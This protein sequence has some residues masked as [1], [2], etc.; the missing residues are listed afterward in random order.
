MKRN[1]GTLAITTMI[2]LL[3]SASFAAEIVTV[4]NFI[5]AETDRTLGRYVEL[6]AFGRVVHLRTPSPVDKQDVIR[7]RSPYMITLFRKRTMA[8]LPTC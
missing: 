7:S 3:A 2:L 1:I 6:D 4:D 8:N 5:R